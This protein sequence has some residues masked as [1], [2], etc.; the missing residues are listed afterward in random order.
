MRL[1]S[2]CA[3]VRACVRARARACAC[4]CARVCVC[5]KINNEALFFNAIPF[6]KFR[7]F[8]FLI[9]LE[10]VRSTGNLSS[11]DNIGAYVILVLQNSALTLRERR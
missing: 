5:V 7:L 9:G 6:G 2:A 8:Y 4:A 3:C 10:V 1:Y 11:I